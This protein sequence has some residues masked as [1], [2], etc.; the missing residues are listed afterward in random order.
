MA[1]ALLTGIPLVLTYRFDPAVVVEAIREHRPTFTVAAI[2]A[3]VALANAPGA[4]SD[5]LVS[6]TTLLTGG[7]PVAPAIVKSLEEQYG[8]YIQNVY[9]MTETTSPTHATPMNVRGPVARAPVRSRSDCRCRACAWRWWT[10]TTQTC[11]SARS[12]S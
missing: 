5:D 8:T 2:T 12:A 3:Y 1:A 7:A 6:F 11:R 10:S 4:Q 9:G